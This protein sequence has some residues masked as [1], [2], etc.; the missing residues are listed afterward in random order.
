MDSNDE[1][2][3][4]DWG[5]GGRLT[6]DLGALARNWQRLAALAG[7]AETGAAVKGDAYGIGLEPAARA[8]ARAG[9]RTFFVALPEEGLRLRAALPEAVIYVLNGLAPR[10]APHL[11]GAGLRPVLG[12]VA[13]IEDWA[14][15]RNGGG[16]GLAAVHVDTGMNRLGLTLDEAAGLS[17]RTSPLG[18][19]L[20]MSHLACADRAAHPLNAIQLAA[21]QQA[22][23]LFP[24]LPASLANSA[25]LHLGADYRFDL[26]RPGIAL[27]GGRFSEAHPPLETVA[28]VETRVVQVRDVA[29]GETVGYGAM[30]T[31]RRASRIAILSAGYADGYHRMAGSSDGARGSS[32]YLRGC[33][34][35]LVGRISMDL[36][37]VDVTDIPDAARGDYAELFGPNIPI[38]DVAAFAG[39]IGYELLTS[40]GH[41]Y[42][43]RYLGGA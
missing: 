15:Y 31:M 41:R 29:A 24:E 26:A 7:G 21:F 36:M 25:G 37:A 6:V 34:A 20:V 23:A 30:E 19:A 1:A 35:P 4:G 27:Y 5:S 22:A 42:R 9:C 10:A 16:T 11:A 2:G 3:A 43:R 28:R 14:T 17:G 40:L 33:R 38:D 13:E 32:A 8:L 18:L 39:T 12:S